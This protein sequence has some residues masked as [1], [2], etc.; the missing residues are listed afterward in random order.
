MLWHEERAQA[1]LEFALSVSVFL[2]L[3]FALLDIGRL[4]YLQNALVAATQEGARYL[5]AHPTASVSQVEDQITRRVVGFRPGELSIHIRHPA[6][7]EVE[8]EA[9]YVY[10]SVV[11]LPFFDGMT[12]RARTRMRY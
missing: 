12:L 3:L 5:V 9:T 7:H 1:T 11:P 6:A 10:R 4:V 8:V 2:L